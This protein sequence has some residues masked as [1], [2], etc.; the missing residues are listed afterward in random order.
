MPD[1]KVL[2]IDDDKDDIGFLAEALTQAGVDSIHYVFSAMQAFIYLE[3]VASD[4]LPK[5]IITD[6]Y[7]PGIKGSEFL[8]DLKRMDNYKHIPVIVL[9]TVKTPK[10]I[11]KYRQM[12]AL[13]YLVKP[14]SYEEYLA[15][16][17]EMKGKLDSL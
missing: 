3:T 9:S 2:I 14:S 8:D 12:G 13:D 5:L 4:C 1:C 17:A 16:A 7:L 6:L 15:V 10:E 11:E